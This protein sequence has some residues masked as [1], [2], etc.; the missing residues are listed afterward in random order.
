MWW[1]SSRRGRQFVDARKQHQA[2]DHI[3]PPPRTFDAD[4]LAM[5][6]SSFDPAPPRILRLFLDLSREDLL[7]R[8]KAGLEVCVMTSP[9]QTL[10]AM[11]S[12]FRF[13]FPTAPPLTSSTI[14][15]IGTLSVLRTY[16][17]TNIFDPRQVTL[18]SQSKTP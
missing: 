4:V 6:S 13:Q 18:K 8:C 10:A 2:G 12:I 15:I 3:R 5:D 9:G 11:R 1:F 7:S 16:D 14:Y 17:L